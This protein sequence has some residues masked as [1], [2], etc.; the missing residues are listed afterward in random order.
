M[1]RRVNIKPGKTVSLMG[2]CMGSLFLLIGIFFAIPTFGAF[3][4]I[5]T[6][7]AAGITAVNGYNAFSKRGVTTH[8]IEIED[9]EPKRLNGDVKTFFD[10][11]KAD[12]DSV[13]ERLAR[14]QELYDQ[15]LITTEEYEQKRK[16][17]LDE[18]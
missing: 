16:S 7:V 15:R 3:G 4:I 14:L 2:F 9:D 12:F 1:K 6:L 18:L 10:G 8:R 13:Q 11:Q 5:W 17:I